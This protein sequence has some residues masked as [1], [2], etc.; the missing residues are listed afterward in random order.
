MSEQILA[1]PEWPLQKE[2][3]K[4]LHQRIQRWGDFVAPVFETMGPEERQA[5]E[6]FFQWLMECVERGDRTTAQLIDTLDLGVR[7]KYVYGDEFDAIRG[8]RNNPEHNPGF[9]PAIQSQFNALYAIHAAGAE[10]LT[11]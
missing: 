2:Y 1:N 9:A 6:P 5:R 3:K 8:D 4:Q 7:D 11:R 10:S